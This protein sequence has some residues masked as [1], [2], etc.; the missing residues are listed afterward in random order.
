VGG[1]VRAWFDEIEGEE[2]AYVVMWG[3]GRLRMKLWASGPSISSFA[4]YIN[5]ELRQYRNNDDT[6]IRDK[7]PR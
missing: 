7:T 3:E 2:D 4:G 5:R 6:G 1:L